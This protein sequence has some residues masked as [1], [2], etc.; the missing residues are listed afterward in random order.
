MGRWK[1]FPEAQHTPLCAH[2]LVLAI[3]TVTQL[4]L[5]E[6][7]S[8]DDAV[9]SF[10]KNH[11]VVSFSCSVSHTDSNRR[12]RL[13]FFSFFFLNQLMKL[14][15]GRL[16]LLFT[17]PSLSFIPTQEKTLFPLVGARKTTKNSGIF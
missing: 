15:S 11:D 8:D 16:S 17:S 12:L 2:Q 14:V 10:R 9:I 1:S 5:G 6:R 7:F 3:K 4:A 13:F